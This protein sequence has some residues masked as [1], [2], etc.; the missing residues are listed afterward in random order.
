[1]A[2]E[3]DPGVGFLEDVFAEPGPVD[4]GLP[5]VDAGLPRGMGAPCEA[6]VDCESGYC[7]DGPEGHVCTV[8]CIASCPPGWEC[9][10]VTN[11]GP[12]IT[13]ICL[14]EPQ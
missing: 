6:N 12:D 1:M 10:G 3:V 2:A 7:V 4:V 14:P 8:T 5:K 11:S 9:K 13:F